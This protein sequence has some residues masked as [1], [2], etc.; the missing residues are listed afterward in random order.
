MPELPEVETLKNY[1]EGGLSGR[2]I[3]KV[4]THRPNLRYKLSDEL[5][6]AQGRIRSIKRRAKYII[7][8]LS[9]DHSLIFH[10]GMSGRLTKRGRDELDLKHDH[11]ILYLDDDSKLVF[12][13]YRRFGMLYYVKTQEVM[14]EKIFNNQGPEPLS[15]AFNSQYLSSK[16]KTKTITIKNI[17]MDN[18][19]VVGVGNIYASESLYLARILPTR[20][21]SSLNMAEIKLLTQKI[22]QV[23]LLSI[24]AGGT[25]LRDF[26]N[27]DNKPGYFKQNLQVYGRNN[28]N[29]YNCNGVILKIKQAGRASFYCSTCQK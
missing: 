1:L 24:K 8:D 4:K 18:S 2:S 6:Q 3:T 14:N 15:D 16:L 5:I 29:C 26:V 23:L 7:I 22:K 27:G 13:D 12:N 25:T 9:N 28:Q 20:A 21:A 11:V 10:L 17:L 19:L